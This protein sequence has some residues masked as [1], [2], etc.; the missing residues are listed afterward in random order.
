[1]RES[2]RIAVRPAGT[3]SFHLAPGTWRGVEGVG[4]AA[5][6]ARADGERGD[7]AE[8]EQKPT[9]EAGQGKAVHRDV[10]VGRRRTRR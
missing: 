4:D 6:D 3:A 1:M 5:R 2:V 7:D 9:L 10:G 8:R